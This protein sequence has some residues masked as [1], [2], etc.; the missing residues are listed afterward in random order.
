MPEQQDWEIPDDAR[1]RVD[2][3]A[4]DLERTLASVVN[5]RAL[6]PEDAFTAPILGTDRLGNG[7]LIRENGI[8]LTI[9]YLVTEAEQVWMTTTDGRVVP[10]SVLAYDHETG[11]GLV[12]AHRPLGIPVVPLGSAQDIR[13]NDPVIVGGGGGRRHALSARV[14][15]K[16]EFAGSWEYVLDQ[17]LFTAP[18]HPSWG[19]AGLIDRQG[20]VAG[21]GSL[22][23]QQAREQVELAGNMF[24]PIDLLRPI[25]DDLART[26]RP[27]TPPRPWLGVYLAQSERSIVVVGL[28]N[29]GPAQKADVRPGDQVIE[30][31]GDQ[32]VDLAATFRRI[33]TL[34]DAGVEVPLTLRRN[35]RVLQLVVGSTERNSI[36]RRPRRH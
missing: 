1:P 30:V 4:F 19:G 24:V 16:R 26:G 13:I 28:A 11:F 29:G 12:Q 23:V 18:A 35:G 32:V 14:V 20:R 10:G 8:V 3:V 2:D 25:F 27:A 17:A 7:I 31:A 5:M 21:I 9:G 6:V 34:G 33:W 15:S 22:F 36:L